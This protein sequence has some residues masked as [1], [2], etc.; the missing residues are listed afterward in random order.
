MKTVCGYVI[1][2][3]GGVGSGE[4]SYIAKDKSSITK[5]IQSA[6]VFKVYGNACRFWQDNAYRI[7]GSDEFIVYEVSIIPKYCWD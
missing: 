1:A 3:S 5:D 6:V 7:A 4:T 2:K